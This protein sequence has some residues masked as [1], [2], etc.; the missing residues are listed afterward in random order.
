[1]NS[2]RVYWWATFGLRLRRAA[3]YR[4]R[5]GPARIAWD[6]ATRVRAL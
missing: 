1:M 5:R 6:V 4:R 2:R 3:Y